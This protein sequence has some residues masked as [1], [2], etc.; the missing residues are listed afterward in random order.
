MVEQNIQCYHSLLGLSLEEK[1][2]LLHRRGIIL[3][4]E[5]LEHTQV[6]EEGRFYYCQSN[7]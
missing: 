3:I 1:G 7:R 2:P 6:G 4:M 5:G